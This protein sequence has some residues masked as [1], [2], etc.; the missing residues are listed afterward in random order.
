MLRKIKPSI[1][2]D[3]D[4]VLKQRN[5][6][7]P[8]ARESLIKLRH[9]DIPIALITNSG[10]EPEYIRVQKINKLFNLESDYSF[11]TNELFLCHTPIQKIIKKYTNQ[12]AL[13]AGVGDV[14]AVMDNYN[15]K[16]YITV[17]EYISIFPELFPHVW[18]KEEYVFLIKL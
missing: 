15:Y 18:Y 8:F 13:I 11:K 6:P 17:E 1:C 16:K 10:G 14:K 5:T 12:L 7:L 9:K 4:G 3:V 2:F